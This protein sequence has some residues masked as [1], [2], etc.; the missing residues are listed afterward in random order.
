MS[1]YFSSFTFKGTASIAVQFAG[2]GSATR[3]VWNSPIW[4][5]KERS[6]A[7]CTSAS[8]TIKKP[9]LFFYSGGSLE[10]YVRKNLLFGTAAS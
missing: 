8:K 9:S 10:G 5:P 7:L 2:M 1:I 3:L 6:C 4:T